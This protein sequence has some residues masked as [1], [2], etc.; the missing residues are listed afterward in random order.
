MIIPEPSTT[1]IN[2]TVGMTNV[3]GT[4]R[5]TSYR[6]IPPRG[7]SQY[8][9]AQRPVNITLGSGQSVT[10]QGRT[11]SVVSVSANALKYMVE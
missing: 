4:A 1:T 3:Y 7:S 11:L 8:A 9:T 2:G 5:S 6:Y 10:I